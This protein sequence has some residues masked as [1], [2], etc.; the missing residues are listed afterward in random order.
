MK[1][2][3]LP[4]A[5]RKPQ[6]SRFLQEISKRLHRL[7]VVVFPARA[8]AAHIV[9]PLQPVLIE[10]AFLDRIR[11][12]GSSP[13]EL[14]EVAATLRNLGHRNLALV[15]EDEADARAVALKVEFH[16]RRAELRQFGQDLLDQ[17]VEL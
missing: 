5:S 9:R 14:R 8:V 12:K 7:S 11:A 13:A 1:A 2:A 4:S 16:Q 17:G 15:F 10:K 6:V 3:Y